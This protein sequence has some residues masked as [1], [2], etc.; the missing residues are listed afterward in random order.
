MTNRPQACNDAHRP[1]PVRAGRLSGSRSGSHCWRRSR[2]GRRSPG[3]ARLGWT[4][5]RSP[6]RSRIAPGLTA[7][8]IVVTNLGSTVAMAVLAV[9]VGAWRGWRGRR[10][11]A[12]LA[13]GA[14]AG[15][16]LVFRVLKTTLYRSRPPAVDELVPAANESPP[17][18][19][20]TMSIVVI[21]TIVVLAGQAAAHGPDGDGG[22]RRAVGRRGRRHPGVPRRGLG[23][24][25]ARGLG[26]G[27]GLAGGL[28]RRLG[29]VARPRRA[30]DLT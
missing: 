3:R 15:A 26:R 4:M 10:A 11:D 1:V 2:C 28:R 29:A 16:S 8:A 18:G 9:A 5:R 21:G 13:V 22:G 17:S 25:R 30:R 7:V 19:L 14:M 12:V 24:R 23:F 6:S 20:A 27:R